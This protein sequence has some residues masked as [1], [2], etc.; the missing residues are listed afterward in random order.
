MII[1]FQRAKTGF[2]RTTDLLNRLI[3]FSVNT[4]L[5]TSLT[6]IIT[7]VLLEAAPGTF[8]Y[9]FYHDRTVYTNCL[10]IT[11]NGREQIRNASQSTSTGEFGMSIPLEISNR[12]TNVGNNA[13]IDNT[14]NHGTKDPIAIR[15]NQETMENFDDAKPAGTSEEHFH[16]PHSY[17]K[18]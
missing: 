1:L 17:G 15:I 14:A 10:L 6:S 2:K 16:Q 18:V 3:L 5:P 7:V 11:L 9:I 4:G 8:I 13:T 12:R